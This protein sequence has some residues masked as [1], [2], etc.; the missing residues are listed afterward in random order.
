MRKKTTM[1]Q[2]KKCAV[3]LAGRF[4]NTQNT[5][6][7]C[8][9]SNNKCQFDVYL[10]V[11]EKE[12]RWKD[13]IVSNDVAKI[14][15]QYNP[16]KIKMSK[17]IDHFEPFTTPSFFIMVYLQ[18]QIIGLVNM[19][20]D[21]YVVSRPDIIYLQNIQFENMVFNDD[22]VYC[23]TKNEKNI[24]DSCDFCDWIF[25]C[26]AHTLL[27]I[28]NINFNRNPHKCNEWNFKQN[29]I[30]NGIVIKSLGFVDT[31]IIYTHLY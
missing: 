17:L 3:L 26:N 19:D 11:W 12:Y 15:E 21:Y 7:N 14:Q 27:K 31:D 24:S 4:F 25:V 1:E 8:L 28:K 29:Y 16:N 23:Y 22:V 20:Y 18:K 9:K 13:T 2:N 30:S 10:F 5:I 6:L